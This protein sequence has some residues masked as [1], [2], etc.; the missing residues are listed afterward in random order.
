[1]R[2]YLQSLAFSRGHVSTISLHCSEGTGPTVSD[3]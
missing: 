2:M 3:L 1:L